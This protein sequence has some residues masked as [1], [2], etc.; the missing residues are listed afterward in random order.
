MSMDIS[1]IQSGWD[2]YGS[3]GDKIGDVNEVGSNYVLVTKGLLFTKDVYIP[4][5]TITGIEHD[6]VYVNFTKD[7]VDTLGYDQPPVDDGY[8][9]GA[10]YG[11]TAGAVYDDDTTVAT[12]S[13]TTSGADYVMAEQPVQETTQYAEQPAQTTDADN[14]RVQRFEEELQ[15]EKTERETGAV[16][17][18][19]DVVEEERTLEVPVTREEVE[20]RSVTPSETTADT[21]Q[22]FQDQTIEVPVREE[23]VEVRKQARVAEELEIE[24]RAV[25]ETERVTDTVRKEVVNV[26]PAGDV[27]VD[28]NTD[29]GRS[30]DRSR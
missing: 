25:Q 12:Q 7:Q 23:D 19:K 2:V 18:D 16:R 1:Q 10:D 6:R 24:K 4:T 30:S 21:S 13:T 8:T 3:D 5:S 26:D 22:A 28:R 9:T 15:A 14:L 11:T 27:D 29:T 20:V 17:V